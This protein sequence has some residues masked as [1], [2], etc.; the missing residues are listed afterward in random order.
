LLAERLI[1]Q[2]D[3]QTH[4]HCK[5]QE[6][7]ELSGYFIE[8]ISVGPEHSLAL[9]SGGEVWGWGQNGDGQLGLGHMNS[10]VKEPTRI[11][12]LD[13]IHIRQVRDNFVLRYCSSVSS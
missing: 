7:P 8:D 10:P 6:V 11:M 4:N 9:G 12:A 3:F 1:G 5:P 2:P 13:G